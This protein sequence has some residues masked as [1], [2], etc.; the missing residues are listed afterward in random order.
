VANPSSWA[1][2]L[3]WEVKLLWLLG[4]GAGL[5]GDASGFF[6]HI[7]S[8]VYVSSVGSMFAIRN[9]VPVLAYV[10]VLLL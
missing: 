8:Y 4:V 10:Y 1:L 3:H 6:F 2:A 9:L 5:G 7:S